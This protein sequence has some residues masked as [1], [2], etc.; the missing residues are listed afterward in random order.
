MTSQSIGS[1]PV[2]E[3]LSAADALAEKGELVLAVE[4]YLAVIAGQPQLAP[5]HYRL[6]TAYQRQNELTKPRHVSGKRLNCCQTEVCGE[7]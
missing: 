4:A 5:A 6:G 2:D 7:C 1:D 3:R